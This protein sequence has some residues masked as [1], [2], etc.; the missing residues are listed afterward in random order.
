[1]V[2]ASDKPPVHSLDEDKV[3]DDDPFKDKADDEL[4]PDQLQERRD[5]MKHYTV[6]GDPALV[7]KTYQLNINLVSADELPKVGMTGTNP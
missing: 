2:G 6:L 1:M 4:T 7:R 3:Q 5:R